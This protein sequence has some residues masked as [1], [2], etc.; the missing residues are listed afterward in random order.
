M[1][2][3]TLRIFD[4]YTMTLFDIRLIDAYY[5]ADLN[6]FSDLFN[7]AAAKNHT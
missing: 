4:P 7:H 6:K 1:L 3:P 2:V 5:S